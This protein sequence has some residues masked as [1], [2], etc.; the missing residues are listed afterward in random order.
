MQIYPF[1]AANYLISKHFL[2]LDQGDA[3][4]SKEIAF[5]FLDCRLK[6][7]DGILPNSLEIPES[8][9]QNFDNLKNFIK[10]SCKREENSHIVL[11]KTCNFDKEEESLVQ[12]V[13]HLLRA[14]DRNYI[15][16]ATGGYQVNEGS[17]LRLYPNIFRPSLKNYKIEILLLRSLERKSICFLTGSGLSLTKY[18]Y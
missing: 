15:S 8:A 16:I 13:I 4:S 6:K 1:E 7:D 12:T 2:I 14:E 18:L 11:L 10:D 5:R 17:R 9:F 3:V